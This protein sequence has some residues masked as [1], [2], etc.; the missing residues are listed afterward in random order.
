MT[1]E[2]WKRVYEK[3]EMNRLFIQLL[4]EVIPAYE[5]LLRVLK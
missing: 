3:A 1:E 2:F 5:Q 4:K